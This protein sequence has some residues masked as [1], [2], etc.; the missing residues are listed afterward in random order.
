MRSAGFVCGVCVAVAPSVSA[1]QSAVRDLP[2]TY[3]PGGPPVV[4]GIT[5][6]SPGSV[7]AVGVE[8]Q[9]PLNW[10]VSSISHSGFFDA[11]SRKV[12]WGPFFAPSIPATI[13]YEL[14]PPQTLSGLCFSGTVSFDVARM[15]QEIKAGKVEYRVDKAGIVHAP[16]GKA[17]FP[18]ADLKENIE[19]VINHIVK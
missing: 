8:D 17:S 12:K 16:V 3:E 7:A 13:S 4:V 1:A 19:S 11:Q 2:D 15:V 10:A 6:V 9:P 18:D 14:A 5:I